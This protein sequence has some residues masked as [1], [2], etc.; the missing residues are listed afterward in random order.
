MGAG[1]KLVGDIMDGKALKSLGVGT[2]F[3]VG[4]DVY[5]GVKEYREARAEGSTVLGATARAVGEA[6]VSEMLG[7]GYLGVQAAIQLPRL[8]VRAWEGIN[9]QARSMAYNSR[10]I[11]FQNARFNDTPQAYTMRQ[12]GMQLAKAAKYNLQQTML[13]NEAQ[14]LHM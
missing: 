12:A 11:P 9:Q 10:N 7:F 13:G 5:F 14:Y 1:T 6:V 8:G 2:L 3:G 4:L